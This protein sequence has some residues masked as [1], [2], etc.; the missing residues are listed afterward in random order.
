[1]GEGQY[2]ETRAVQPGSLYIV[3][4]PIGNLRDITL[5]AIEVLKQVDLV[6]AEDTRHSRK[7]FAEYGIE[8]PMISYHDF[9]KEKQTPIIIRKLREG[10][11]VALVSDAGTPGISDPGFY[12]IREA[13]QQQIRVE[14]VPG[15]TAFVPALILSGLPLH[16]FVFEGFPPA[17]KGRKSFF[18]NL[19]QEKRTVILFE[20]PHRLRRTLSDIHQH[21][22]NRRIAIARELTKKFEEVIRGRVAEIIN[23]LGDKPV[24]GEIVLVIEGKED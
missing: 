18:E 20:S 3:S 22:G 21:L 2:D 24:K 4:T 9:N 19:A 10:Q 14:A 1:M 13:L 6:A 11:S 5:R 7:L 23:K 12:L 16:R 8:T 15:P 17:K